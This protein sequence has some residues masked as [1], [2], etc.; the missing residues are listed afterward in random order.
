MTDAARIGAQAK[1]ELE[2]TQRAFDGLE[3]ILLE[4]IASSSP[5]EGAKRERLYA[6]INGL[7]RVRQALIIAASNTAVEDYRKVLV[8]AG[9]AD[10]AD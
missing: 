6:G 7:R 4:G 3:V 5:D 2:Q 10:L 8:E 9:F 1:I